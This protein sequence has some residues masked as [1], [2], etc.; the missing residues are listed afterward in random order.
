M[1]VLLAGKKLLQC[2]GDD[3]RVC[4]EESD[5]SLLLGYAFADDFA[6][7]LGEM[8]DWDVRNPGFVRFDCLIEDVCFAQAEESS[9]VF[10]FFVWVFPSGKQVHGFDDVEVE[11]FFHLNCENRAADLVPSLF[12]A[13][14]TGF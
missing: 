5:Q 13:F 12:N 11:F 2:H 6:C 9:A 7:G 3:K 1:S 14:G 4:V 8:T 10:F